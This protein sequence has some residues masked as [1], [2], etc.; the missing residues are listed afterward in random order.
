MIINY[1][2]CDITGPISPNLT[3]KIFHLKYPYKEIPSQISSPQSV[4]Q[5]Q[6]ANCFE[7]T[8]VLVSLLIGAGYDAYIVS[9]YA[10]RQICNADESHDT[11]PPETE[12]PPPTPPTPKKIR[13]YQ[14][15]GA[16]D[17]TSKFEAMMLERERIEIERLEK[18][19]IDNEFKEQLLKES[20]SE[21][22]LH[23][24]RIH[25]WI[26]SKFLIGV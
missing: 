2:G 10:T 13:K 6:S 14:V 12:E 8:N 20:P 11:C 3:K 23:G 25:S 15:R 5:N 19:R 17:L 1:R 16:K 9:G 22:K 24:R 4:I 26:L 21:D 7:Y 18:E